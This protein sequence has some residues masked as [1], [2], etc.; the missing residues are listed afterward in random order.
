M[1]NIA[2]NLTDAVNR[3]MI[4]DA[5]LA[6]MIGRKSDGVSPAVYDTD[7]AETNEEY[8][9][10]IWIISDG[11]VSCVPL[12]TKTTRGYEIIRDIRLYQRRTGSSGDIELAGD[13]VRDLFHRYAL[14]VAG[15]RDATVAHCSG[16]SKID[17]TADYVGY[18]VT[19]WWKIEAI[20][21]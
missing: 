9:D 11:N 8:P 16:P 21:I 20:A 13:R 1:G 17:T 2:T 6:E 12:D 5:Q 3:Y 18:A 15:F 4:E 10:G 7:P 19:C 14:P